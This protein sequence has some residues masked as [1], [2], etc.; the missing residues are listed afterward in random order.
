LDRIYRFH[1][2][3]GN[4]KHAVG[5]ILIRLSRAKITASLAPIARAALLCIAFGFAAKGQA[6]SAPISGSAGLPNLGD[7]SEL[8]PATE[9][10]LGNRIAKELY[11]DPDYI[12]DAIVG[13]YVDEIWQPLLAAARL[14]GELPSTLGE[15][16]AWRILLGRDRSVNAFALP[17]AYLGLHLGLVGTVSSRDELA[18]VLAHELSHITQRHIARIISRQSAQTPWLIGAMILGAMAASKNPSAGNAMMVGGQAVAAQSQLNFSRDMEREA[19]RVG[20]GIA[21]QAGFA[22]QGFVSMFEKLQQSGRLN[23]AGGFPYLRSHPLSSDRMADM[24]ARI[25]APAS[26]TLPPSAEAALIAARARVLS[27][28]A[29]DALRAWL[30]QAN[31]AALAKLPLAQQQ[32]SLYAAAMSAARLRN[33]EA[34]PS[35]LDRLQALVQGDAGALRQVRYLRAETALARDQAADALAALGPVASPPLRAEVLLRAQAQIRLG[36]S[37]VATQTLQTWT[38]DHRDDALAWQWL[39]RALADQGRTVASVRAEAEANV[40]QLDY[41]AALA[42]FKA[43]QELARN[44]AET[45]HFEASI[46]DTRRREIEQLLREQALE[47]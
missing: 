8:S 3:A 44:A 31:P 26:P 15:A 12:D 24:Q 20:F 33:Y 43:A 1:Y 17:G 4:Y 21:G 32:L 27:N 39:A 41:D 9:R 37:R 14:R 35:L 42:R 22:P 40:A 6:E 25:P 2:G 28:P 29:V 7:I 23:D 46:V 5:L 10:R 34:L 11:R 13:D 38:A 18:A 30:V 36:Q 45:D 47:R 19:D 16:Y